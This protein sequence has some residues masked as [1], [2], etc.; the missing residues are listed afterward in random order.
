MCWL[1]RGVALVQWG[2]AARAKGQRMLEGHCHCG[3]V[4]WRLAALP[5]SVTACSCTACRRYGALWAYGYDEENIV[6][7]GETAVYQRGRSLTFHFCPSCG[8]V[9][10][11][12]GLEVDEHG[13]R[14]MAVNLR[15]AEPGPI[16]ALPIDH[17]DGLE[18]WEDLPRNGRCV[19]DLWF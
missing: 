18:T 2:S 7:T 8:G 5:E 9:S 15:M 11:W 13:R 6:V 1:P 17:F 10:H 12:R 16:A 19:A 14:R 4:R 3:A